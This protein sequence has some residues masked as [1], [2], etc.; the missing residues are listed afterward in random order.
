MG[1]GTLTLDGKDNDQQS[2]IEVL[3]T[4]GG[5]TFYVH[6]CYEKLGI[7][8]RVSEAILLRDYLTKYIQRYETLLER[9]E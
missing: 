1:I 5:L 9:D 4:H 8:L 2:F 3:D 7:D 6:D